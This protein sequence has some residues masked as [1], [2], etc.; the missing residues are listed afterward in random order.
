MKASIIPVTPYQQNCSL[1]WCEN[2]MKGAVI[3]PGG[4]LDR[5]LDEAEKNGVTIEN[6]FMTHSHL[7]HAG[8]TAELQKKLGITIEGPHKDD[9][10]LIAKLPDECAKH[11]FP[12][13]ETFTPD[14][15][16]NNGDQVSV[17]DL[18]LDV[19]H[20]PGH[21]PGHVVFHDP[22]SNIAFVGDV[23]F[24]GSIGRTDFERGNHADL[25][26]AI[27]DRLWPLGDEVTFV[28]GH[29]DLSTFGEERRSNPY[30]GDGV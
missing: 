11:G 16:L 12:A 19:Y 8:G 13:A 2:T 22:Q 20:C 15:W 14:R 26:S 28:S 5:V 4:D 17:G 7:D 29:G 1:I 24:K 27:R 9:A 25:I 23:L 30:V 18:T 10:W 3:D 21:T 6:I